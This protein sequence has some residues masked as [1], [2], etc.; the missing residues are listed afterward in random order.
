MVKLHGS[1][2]RKDGEAGTIATVKKVLGRNTPLM[3]RYSF[4]GK[5]GL[6]NETLY[7]A[8]KAKEE[9]Y[10]PFKSS[11]EKMKDVTKYGGFT[12]VTGAFLLGRT[13][14]KEK[15]KPDD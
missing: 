7:S 11:D 2:R 8:K 4:E 3:T 12:S 1:H 14:G 5:G 10:I 15:T 13:H 6:T 9:G